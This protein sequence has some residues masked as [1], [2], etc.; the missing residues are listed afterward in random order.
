MDMKKNLLLMLSLLLGSQLCFGQAPGEVPATAMPI[1]THHYMHELAY[2]SCSNMAAWNNQAGMHVAFGSADRLYF[3]REVPSTLDANLASAYSAVAWRGERVNAQI[4]VWSADAQEQ[5]R[6]STEGLVSAEGNKIAKENIS[7]ELVRYVL[8][9]YP[10]AEK[11]AVCGNSPYT[12]GYLMPDRFETFDRFDLP[13]KTV[14]P[15][16]MLLDVPRGTM[17]GTYKGKVEV[18]AKGGVVQSLDLEVRVQNQVLPYPKDWKYRLD[19]WQNPWAVAWYNDVEPWSPEHK[20]LLKQHLKL[21]AEAGGTYIT[22]YG[23]HSPWGDNSYMIEGGMIEW[24]KKTDGIWAFDYKI[25]DEYVELAMECGINKAITLYTAIPWGFRHR[26]MDEATGD[27]V[28]AY[29]APSSK[30]FADM[31]NV[32][33][34]DFKRHLE[35]KGW[36]DITYIGINENPKEETLAAIKVVRAHDKCWKITYAGNWHKDLDGLLDDYSFLYGN[37]PTVAEQQERSAEGRTSTVYVCCNPPIPNN[38]LF[39]PP[40]EG[41]WISWYAMAHGYN[42]FLRWAYDAWPEDVNRDGR[43]GSWPAG[44]CFMVYPGGKSCIRFEKMREGIVD[45]EKMRILKEK[46]SVSNLPE[47][48]KLVDALD[49]H[50]QVFLKEKDFDEKKIAADVSKGNQ[51]VQDLSDL[52]ADK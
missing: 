30:E 27:Y 18:R 38:F 29:W 47:V 8:A 10:Y 4:L 46:A 33:L 41:R 17:P 20:M 21:Y 24:L 32:F 5:V 49:K 12:A 9:N 44:D 36:L 2:D 3:R 42:G 31:W 48:K 45:Y 22:T 19:L 26:Y 7:F 15:V 16:W 37:E 50:L 14:R 52:L 34:T 28:Y 43:H 11:T 1:R 6:V 25:F 40:I 39:S 13:E 51:I 35:A 23:V